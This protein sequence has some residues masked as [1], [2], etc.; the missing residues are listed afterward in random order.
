MLKAECE[1]CA[2]SPHQQP[3]C[4]PRPAASQESDHAAPDRARDRRITESTRCTEQN[5]AP[6]L[7]AKIREVESLAQSAGDRSDGIGQKPQG[8]GIRETEA[9]TKAWGQLQ[10][11]STIGQAKRQL[12][13]ELRRASSQRFESGDR[14]PI[15][16]GSRQVRLDDR[17]TEHGAGEPLTLH[18][19]PPNM[20]TELSQEG[21]HV[22]ETLS[23][24]IKDRIPGGKHFLALGVKVGRKGTMRLRRP[25]HNAP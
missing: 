2:S 7:T 22:G 1:V 15:K 4:C 25:A 11:S 17:L 19:G 3:Q 20:R 18:G 5:S 16:P 8:F 14:P 21:R 6:I 10:E 12:V 13:K 24:T 9:V 23:K